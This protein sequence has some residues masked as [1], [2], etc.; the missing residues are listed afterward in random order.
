M[1]KT[2]KNL[3]VLAF[4]PCSNKKHTHAACPLLLSSYG[5]MKK[6]LAKYSLS[7]GLARKF[8]CQVRQSFLGFTSA[9][10]KIQNHPWLIFCIAGNRNAI[11][12]NKCKFLSPLSATRSC[13]QT[14]NTVISI[15]G[16]RKIGCQFVVEYIGIHKP[17]ANV[18][19][20]QKTNVVLGREECWTGWKQLC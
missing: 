13:A 15:V 2:S 20:G 6:G 1:E 7:W 4:L 14:A 19:A 8:V 3:S 9:T 11:T 12:L 17:P 5:G 16:A 18:W 10:W